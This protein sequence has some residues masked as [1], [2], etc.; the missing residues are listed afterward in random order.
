[1][2]RI[3]YYSK[4]NKYHLEHAST[5]NEHNYYNKID[6]YYPNGTARYFYTKAEWDAY[7]EAEARNKYEAN[8][9]KTSTT[10]NAKTSEPVVSLVWKDE[11]NNKQT[12]AKQNEGVKNPKDII[13]EDFAKQMDFKFDPTK[14]SITSEDAKKATDT[15]QGQELLKG[16][17]N[18]INYNKNKAAEEAMKKAEQERYSKIYAENNKPKA[19]TREEA[20]REARKREQ[21][22]IAKAELEASRSPESKALEKAEDE[23]VK[24]KGR[25]NLA[26]NRGL[27]KKENKK[28]YDELEKEIAKKEKEVADWR[29]KISNKATTGR[30]AAIKEAHEKE[31]KR[32]EERT[33]AKEENITNNYKKVSKEQVKKKTD[34]LRAE[35]E[36]VY[37]GTADNFDK[38]NFAY[39]L[40]ESLLRNTVKDFKN[41]DGDLAKWLEPT[42]LPFGNAKYYDDRKDIIEAAINKMENTMNSE[43]DKAKYEDAKDGYTYYDKLMVNSKYNDLKK[44]SKEGL[45]K[46]MAADS[47]SLLDKIKNLF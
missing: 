19:K 7:Q 25:Q 40:L 35:V 46:L 27:D 29:K 16:Y 47:K 34:D 8:K 31:S 6:K 36:R 41:Y 23:L 1:M 17:N 3:E 38:D 20:E 12:N 21:E 9:K 44:K 22:R 30:D 43:I 11:Q 28:E 18:K 33:K 45:D 37:K 4:L 26:K 14:A 39:K 5:R 2:N 32:I 10:G 42:N 15:I 24:L 13:T